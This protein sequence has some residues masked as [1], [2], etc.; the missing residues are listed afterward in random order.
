MIGLTISG[1][2][3]G[4]GNRL[5]YLHIKDLAASFLIDVY[6]ATGASDHAHKCHILSSHSQSFICYIPM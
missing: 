6:M 2:L 1:N 4:K 3:L 5:G